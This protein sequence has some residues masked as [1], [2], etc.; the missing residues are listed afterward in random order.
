MGTFHLKYRDTRPILEVVLYNPDD[1]VHDLTGSTSWKLH[2]DISL[3][4]SYDPIEL[5]RDMVIFGAPTNGTLRYTWVSGDWAAGTPTGGPYTAGG[6]VVGPS[7]PLGP[8]NIEHRMEFEVIDGTSRLTF[9]NSA[10]DTLQIISDIGQ[11]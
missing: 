4:T 2:I 9:P 6:L 11:G 8:R 10:Y 1:T 3:G 7:I 5:T